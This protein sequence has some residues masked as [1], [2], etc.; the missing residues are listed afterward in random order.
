MLDPRLPT[1]SGHCLHAAAP[2]GA[3]AYFRGGAGG[4][5]FWVEPKFDLFVALMLQSPQLRV[6]CR[7]PMHDMVYAAA[8]QW[9]DRV[10]SRGRRHRNQTRPGN[11]R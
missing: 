3:G 1:G 2:A 10:G 7:A 8:M 6:Y 4:T 9:R 11:T 5:Y